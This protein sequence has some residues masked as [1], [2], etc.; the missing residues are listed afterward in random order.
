[1]VCCGSFQVVSL[2]YQLPPTR[3]LCM[4]VSD[5]KRMLNMQPI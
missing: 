4:P 3:L 1:M 5:V 2:A